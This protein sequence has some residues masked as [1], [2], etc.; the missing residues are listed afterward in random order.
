MERQAFQ[1]AVWNFCNLSRKRGEAGA[2]RAKAVGNGGFCAAAFARLDNDLGSASA[3]MRAI[4]E[5]AVEPCIGRV[6][7]RIARRRCGLDS[8]ANRQTGRGDETSQREE[9]ASNHW[10]GCSRYSVNRTVSPVQAH[11]RTARRIERR[12]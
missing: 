4:D 3:R 11:C 10:A 8:G 6:G 9:R 12:A 5:D 7:H 1:T 2:G